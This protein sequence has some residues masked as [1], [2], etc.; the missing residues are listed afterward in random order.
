MK[1][2]SINNVFRILLG[3]I[4]IILGIAGLFLPFL[5]GVLFISTGL[6][7]IGG[8]PVLK[9]LRKLKAYLL[10]KFFYN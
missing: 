9:K 8:K 2:N 10:K 6:I 4:L 1:I 5:Q 3:L 7:L